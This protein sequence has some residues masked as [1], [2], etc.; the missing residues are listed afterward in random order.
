MTSMHIDHISYMKCMALWASLM[1]TVHVYSISDDLHMQFE[2]N[3]YSYSS[4]L[5]YTTSEVYTSLQ[6]IIQLQPWYSLIGPLVSHSITLQISGDIKR[7]DRSQLNNTLTR[8]GYLC[9]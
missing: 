4:Q 5:V 3:T 9:Y 8:I 2:H 7:W 1:L 6:T